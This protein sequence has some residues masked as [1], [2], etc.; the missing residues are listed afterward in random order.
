MGGHLTFDQIERLIW[1][2]HPSYSKIEV[3]IETGT[4]YGDTAIELSPYFKRIIT[5]ELSQKLYEQ[6]VMR[7]REKSNVDFKWGNSV[8][9]LPEIL[10][11]MDAKPILFYLDAHGCLGESEKEEKDPPLLDELKIINELRNSSD[12]VVID[13]C[14]CF[15]TIFEQLDWTQITEESILASL[16]GKI[17]DSY[18]E[19]DKM[20]ILTKPLQRK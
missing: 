6:S 3:V 13:D 10:R 5:I 8:I 14:K 1:R 2:R 9:L 20:F 15:G 19:E 7:G 11:N 12:V 4:S 18:I 17:Y 16:D